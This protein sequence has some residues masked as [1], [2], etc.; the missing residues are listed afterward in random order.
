M[1]VHKPFSVKSC[2]FLEGREGGGSKYFLGNRIPLFWIF[3]S[4]GKI[5][6]AYSNVPCHL[7]SD[8]FE[9]EQLW[10]TAFLLRLVHTLC[11]AQMFG[12]LC[13]S[14]AV[15]YTASAVLWV[16][17]LNRERGMFMG[18]YQFMFRGLS[19][20]VAGCANHV[21]GVV[22]GSMFCNAEGPTDQSQ[23][24]IELSA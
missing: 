5:F 14:T 11:L 18:M 16:V 19:N 15:Q 3:K 23:K 7:L 9:S 20:Y 4:P 17:W 10:V 12:K 24:S 21:A 13:M 2:T 6:Y 22:P 8:I 1:R